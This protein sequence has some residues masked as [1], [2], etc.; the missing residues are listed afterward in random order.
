MCLST[1]EWNGRRSRRKRRTL[2]S[3]HNNVEGGVVGVFEIKIGCVLEVCRL[4]AKF[5]FLS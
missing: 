4:L 3:D 5:E 1:E 2:V